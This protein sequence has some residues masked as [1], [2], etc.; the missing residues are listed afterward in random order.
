MLALAFDNSDSITEIALFVESEPQ[1]NTALVTY[2]RDGQPD[3]MMRATIMYEQS[4]PLSNSKE[5]IVI[6]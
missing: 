3:Y 1:N 2:L 6:N 4:Y 5:L